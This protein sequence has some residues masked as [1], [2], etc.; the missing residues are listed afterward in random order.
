MKI[1]RAVSTTGRV[2]AMAKLKHHSIIR[3]KTIAVLC[4]LAL[5]VI[6]VPRTYGFD[7]LSSRQIGTSKVPQ[8][9]TPVM[10]EQD[11]KGEIKVSVWGRDYY[12]EN[13]PFPFRIVSQGKELLAAPV[14]LVG[15]FFES[16]PSEPNSPG[17]GVNWDWKK[18]GVIVWEHDDDHATLMGWM[19]NAAMAINAVVRIDFDGFMRIDISVTSDKPITD[20]LWWEIPISRERATL[21]HYWPGVPVR[22]PIPISSI[23][24]SGSVPPTGLALPFQP[25]VW[26]GW[27]EGGLSWFCETDESWRPAETDRAIEIKPE[28]EAVVFRAH[29]FDS[30]LS[31]GIKTLSFGL[32]SDSGQTMGR[33]LP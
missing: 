9:W 7:D 31:P 12:F 11:H 14:R 1:R 4:Y 33:N 29:L 25:V 6:V 22:W 18:S 20:H 26:L 2:L 17:P 10:V 23:A 30:P 19:Q 16:R 32:R 15:G 8:P 3:K 28:N 13:S 27:E 5:T 21:R 24:S